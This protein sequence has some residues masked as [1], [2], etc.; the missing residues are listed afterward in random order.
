MIDHPVFFVRNVPDYVPFVED[1]RRLKTSGLSL[2]KALAVLRVI[3]SP[4]YRLLRAAMRKTPDSPLRI[5]YWSTTPYRLGSGA[6]KFSARP[7][8]TTV[9]PP[10]PSNSKDKL[11][12]A[13]SAHLKRHEVR[14]DFLVQLQTDPVAMPIEDPTV[15]WDEASLPTRRRPPSVFHPSRSSPPSRWPFARS[16]LVHSLACAGRALPLGWNQPDA[17]GGLRG[18]FAST[19]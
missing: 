14:F 10:S 3:F 11:R 5:R 7:D 12:E 17:Q 16:A 15:A 18:D 19:A 6:M 9:P 8:L 13:M 2:G 1:F 4:R